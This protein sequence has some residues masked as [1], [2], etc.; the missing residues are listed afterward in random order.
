M[1]TIVGY[2]LKN[3]VICARCLRDT[4]DAT[5]PIEDTEEIVW[6]PFLCDRCGD[7]IETK[8]IP[9]NGDE[10][11]YRKML[12]TLE[13][14]LDKLRVKRHFYTQL[15]EWDDDCNIPNTIEHLWKLVCAAENELPSYL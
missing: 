12:A 14:T 5:H 9:P 8:I 7:E 3:G 11:E 4:D 6:P 1:A 15:D 10:F 2:D 13:A